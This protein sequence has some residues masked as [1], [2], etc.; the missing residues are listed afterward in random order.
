MLGKASY[1]SLDEVASQIRLAKAV[2]HY[3]DPEDVPAY[4]GAK[5]ADNIYVLGA[6][7]SSSKL[8]EMFDP[9]AVG[10]IVATRWRRGVEANQIAFEAGLKAGSRTREAIG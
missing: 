5:V 3:L 4:Q 6:A 2:M 7:L 9:V 1:P 10:R 8:G